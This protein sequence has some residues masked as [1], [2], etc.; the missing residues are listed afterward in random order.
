MKDYQFLECR[1]EFPVGMAYVP[2]QHM[3]N[4]YEN[5]EEAF[6]TGTIFPELNKPFTGRR[7]CS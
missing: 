2:W 7:V 4:V 3:E 6:F 5:L 1:N